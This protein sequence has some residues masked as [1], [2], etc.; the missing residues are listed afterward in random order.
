M[1]VK[2][3]Q[4]VPIP[5]PIWLQNALEKVIQASRFDAPPPVLL[6]PTGRWLGWC[7]PLN[8]A[9]DGRV[10]IS[11]RAKFWQKNEVARV[12]L[13]EA[14]HRLMADGLHRPSFFCM[15]LCL[16]LRA[17][18]A[19]LGEGVLFAN[20]ASLYDIQDLPPQLVDEPE[21]GLARSIQWAVLTARQLV[22][23]QPQTSAEGLAS[24]V[25]KRFDE[26]L[27][28]LDQEPMKRAQ[29]VQQVAQRVAMQKAALAGLRERIFALKLVA[30]GLGF[31]VA[32]TFLVLK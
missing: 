13:H 18:L 10:V 29:Q 19:D 21:R 26:W 31:L 3:Y 16:L 11:S 5:V 32:A 9:P 25:Q 4:T 15:N 20:S 23:D 22:Q 1:D 2:T 7:A 12:F 28:E 30:A 27:A 14:A 8:E 6:C 24:E 17:D